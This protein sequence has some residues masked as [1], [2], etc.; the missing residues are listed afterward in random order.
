MQNFAGVCRME[1]R[2]GLGLYAGLRLDEDGVLTIGRGSNSRQREQQKA[3]RQPASPAAAEPA[4]F[5]WQFELSDPVL[6]RGHLKAGQRECQ[7]K[8]GRNCYRSLGF[9]GERTG[10]A[11]DIDAKADDRSLPY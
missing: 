7:R 6:H 8:K 9:T 11:G 4:F 5:R 2:K 1:R 3:E 10:A